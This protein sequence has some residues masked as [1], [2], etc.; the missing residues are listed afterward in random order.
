MKKILK[1]LLTKKPEPKSKLQRA[2]DRLTRLYPGYEIG[3][4][5]YGSPVIHDWKEGSTLKIGAYTSIAAGVNI[6]LG[7]AP[8]R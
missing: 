7:G 1:K 2:N 4:G 8:S 5:S 3:V 6:Y